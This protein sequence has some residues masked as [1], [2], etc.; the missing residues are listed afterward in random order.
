L[1][2]SAEIVD[3]VWLEELSN[4]CS[5]AARARGAAEACAFVKVNLALWLMRSTASPEISP[6]AWDQFRNY[7]V[8][9]GVIVVDRDGT[10][11]LGTARLMRMSSTAPG[12]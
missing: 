6:R 11:S 8:P 7:N 1:T 4:V 2:F 9:D 12:L 5:S 10:C 3:E